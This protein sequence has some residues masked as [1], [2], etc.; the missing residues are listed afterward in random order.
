M[1]KAILT[2]TKI[3][4]IKQAMKHDKGEECISVHLVRTK[5]DLHLKERYFSN[6]DVRYTHMSNTEHAY[7]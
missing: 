1:C 6:V 3:K 7:D 5:I 4:V 2:R